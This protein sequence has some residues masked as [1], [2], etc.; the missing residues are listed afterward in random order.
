MAN[1][2]LERQ[3]ISNQAKIKEIATKHSFEESIWNE[4]DGVRIV[5]YF[6]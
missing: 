6:T 3:T 5:M 4:E 1:H 2:R